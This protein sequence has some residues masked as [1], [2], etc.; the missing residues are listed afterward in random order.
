[1]IV[2]AKQAIADAPDQ[3]LVRRRR[4]MIRRASWAACAACLVAGVAIGWTTNATLG[5]A[6]VV[7]SAGFAFVPFAFHRRRL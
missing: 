4:T 3:H 6:L 2:M 5:A 1:M 7:T